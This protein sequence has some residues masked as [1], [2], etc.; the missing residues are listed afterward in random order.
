MIGVKRE[1]E[2][3]NVDPIRKREKKKRCGWSEEREHGALIKFRKTI[4]SDALI[5]PYHVQSCTG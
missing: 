5:V 2:R 4:K 1:R 3:E